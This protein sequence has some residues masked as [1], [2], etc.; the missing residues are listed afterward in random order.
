M[1]L[2]GREMSL[3]QWYDAEISIIVSV[4]NRLDKKDVGIIKQRL[5]LIYDQLMI[6]KQMI[7]N[8]ADRLPITSNLVTSHTLPDA[9]V[10]ADQ[11]LA[12][13]RT[14]LGARPKLISNLM[15]KFKK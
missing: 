6:L 9:T 11:A 4:M 12:G 5:G 2:L 10:N 15:K 14:N 1:P 8:E 3:S 7:S 13:T